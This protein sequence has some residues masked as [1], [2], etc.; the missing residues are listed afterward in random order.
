MGEYDEGPTGATVFYFPQ[1]ATGVVEVRGGWP[2]TVNTDGLRL[3]YEAKTLD[4]VTFAGGSYY[5][6]SVSAGVADEIRVMRDRKAPADAAPGRGNSLTPAQVVAAIVFD[7]GGRFNTIAPDPDLGRA[8]FQARQ[9]GWFP[10]GAH[11]AGRMTGNGGAFG[12]RK[13]GGQGGAA[14]QIG[15][16][17]V[18]VFAV[19]NGGAVVARN[20]NVVVCHHDPARVARTAADH[21]R[22]LLLPEPERVVL[23]QEE[24]DEPGFSKATNLFLVVTNQTLSYAD[25]Q[26]MAVQVHTSLARAIQPFNTRGDGDILYA[27]ST[28]EVE[29]TAL[30]P[31]RLNLYA[32][33]T[34]WD[35]VLAALPPRPQRAANR[36]VKVD[37]S[38]LDQYAGVY[39]FGAN[40]KLQVRRDGDRLVARST[41]G[42]AIYTFARS[43]DVSL[44]AE[45]N[46]IFY[47][48]TP[49]EDRIEFVK[50]SGGNVDGL[51]FNPGLQQISARKVQ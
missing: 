49:F 31:G 32:S 48:Q 19:L 17:K 45:S 14:R 47:N 22:N 18:L 3:G 1:G 46:T 7:L 43:V 42:R 12:E 2:G 8:A 20:G 28:Q 27:A 44:L 40:A 34:A 51:V 5:G 6:L 13:K 10:L 24:P 15:P 50:G 35:A 36:P 37:A 38:V 9:T 30:D 25:L 33:E 4:S 23:N 29:N 11:G 26:R 21:W 16:T 41:G 39:E